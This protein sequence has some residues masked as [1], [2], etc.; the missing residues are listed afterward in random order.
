M[1]LYKRQVGYEDLG[2]IWSGP[3][4][5][6]TLTLTATTLYFPFML[7]QNMEDIGVYTDTD[8]INNEYV[9]MLGSWSEVIR[10]YSAQPP[11]QQ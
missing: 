8:N 1:E 4:S 10:N 2:K 5:A 11:I 7:T 3:S 9:I 6:V